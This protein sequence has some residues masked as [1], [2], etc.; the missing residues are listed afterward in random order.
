[1]E[2]ATRDSVAGH[3]ESL[4][5]LD[6]DLQ[7]EFGDVY[8]DESWA[9][10]EFLAERPA[11][12]LLSQLA[13]RGE[14]LCGFWIASAVGGHAH[15]H[16]VGVSA[17]WRR[18]GVMSA[19]AEEVHRAARSAGALR[20]TLYLNPENQVARAAYSRLGYRAC[21]LEGRAAMERRLCE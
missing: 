20:M 7:A 6:A 18:R 4:A 2:Q 15:T 17:P 5:A 1:M 9:E 12:W 19:L 8:S 10:Q 14:E 3:A 11:K 13:L 16:R 21:V